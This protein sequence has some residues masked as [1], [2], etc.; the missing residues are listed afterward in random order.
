MAEET[1]KTK[2]KTEVTEEAVEEA[3]EE[4]ASDAAQNNSTEEKALPLNDIV[5]IRVTKPR[6]EWSRR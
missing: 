4:A 1:R 2:K 5:V 3:V 6:K